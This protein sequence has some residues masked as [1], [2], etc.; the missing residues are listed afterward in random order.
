[1][2]QILVIAAAVFGVNVLPAFGPPTWSVLAYFRI[3]EGTPIWV[4]VVVGT[5]AAAMGRYVLA[6]G[7]RSFG[8]HLPGKR[9]ESLE[10]LGATLSGPRGLLGRMAL[11]AVSPVPS[12]TLFEAA[13]LARV[14]LGPLLTAFGAGRLVSYSVSLVSVSAAGGG[15]RDLITGG[16]SS[17]RAIALGILGLVGLVVLV[18]VD[19]VT[20]IDRVRARVA[21]RKGEPAPGDTDLTPSSRD[22][23]TAQIA[24]EVHTMRPL[25]ESLADMSVHAKSVEDRAAAAQQD[26]HEQISARIQQSKADALRRGEAAK[27]RRTEVAQD[28][29][30]RWTSLRADLRN[31]IDQI[32]DAVEERRDEHDAKVAQ[33]HADRA[34]DN[35]IAAIDFAQSAIDAAD[36]AVLE[37]IDARAQAAAIA[38]AADVR[39]SA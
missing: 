12:N 34:E 23:E 18:R 24:Q 14:R 5:L 25:S 26:T 13:G 20:V 35:A 3:T 32:H 27:A 37:A 31:Q 4:L 29:T 17:P 11:F 33:R 10:A 6:V 38:P 19:W 39:A 22:V 21:H 15:I 16:V 8:S 9:R 1:M 36:E 7:F 30:A 2:S 28:I